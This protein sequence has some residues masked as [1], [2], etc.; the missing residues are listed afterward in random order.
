[1]L[2]HR[3]TLCI[4]S[5]CLRYTL[6]IFMLHQ[7]YTPCIPPVY[8]WHTPVYKA[9]RKLD[10]IRSQRS[11]FRRQQCRTT[12]L[13]S[14]HFGKLQGSSPGPLLLLQYGGLLLPPTTSY[15]LLL[16]PTSSYYLLLPHTSS[17]YTSYYSNMV[18]NC[19]NHQQTSVTWC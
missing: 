5:V 3:Y 1:M 12:S 10:P 13:T 15:Y 17:Y 18:A 6:G 16:P 11:M 19:M 14:D 4:L 7:R 8:L 2:P 9:G